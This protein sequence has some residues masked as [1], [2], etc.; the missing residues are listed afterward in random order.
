MWGGSGGIPEGRSV[1]HAAAGPSLDIKHRL[2]A[3]WVTFSSVSMLL[4]TQCLKTWFSSPFHIIHK[5]TPITAVCLSRL[6]DLE[7]RQMDQW[8]KH[9]AGVLW[10]SCRSVWNMTKAKKTHELMFY[11]AAS[12]THYCI[13]HFLFSHINIVW[14][15]LIVIK[16]KML[17]MRILWMLIR[18]LNNYS[19]K[20]TKNRDDFR[21]GSFVPL[22]HSPGGR[23]ACNASPPSRPPPGGPCFGRSCPY[24]RVMYTCRW[25]K[26]VMGEDKK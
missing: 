24:C 8:I 5:C 7:T 2:W 11:S 22:L 12:K 19:N 18:H 9:P 14:S 20:T 21:H 23:L 4:H 10:I 6:F 1:K 16:S 17:Y 15:F 3:C 25:T 26:K 13:T